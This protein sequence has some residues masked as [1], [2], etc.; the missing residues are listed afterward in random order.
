MTSRRCAPTSDGAASPSTASTTRPSRTSSRRWAR[1]SATTRRCRPPPRATFI[2]DSV[3]AGKWRIL[4]GDDAVALDQAVR[5]NPEGAY[6]PDGIG[7]ST[8]TLGR[9]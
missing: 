7:L 4:V 2:L 9:S 5:A 6:G 1:A 3:K 8:V